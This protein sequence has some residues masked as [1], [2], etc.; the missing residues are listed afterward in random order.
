MN[1]NSLSDLVWKSQMGDDSAMEQLLL[2]SYSPILYLSNKILQDEASAMQVTREVLE[3]ISGKLASLGDPDQFQKWMCRITAA[4]CM[5]AMPLFHQYDEASSVPAVWQETLADGDSLTEEQSGQVI[6]QMVDTLP[7]N[8]RLCILLLG[9]GGLSIPAIAQLTGFTDSTVT[10]HI[11]QGQQTIQQHLWELQSR[12][13]QLS[14][15]TSLTGI[16]RVAMFSGGNQEDALPVVYGILG[17]EIPV[18]PDPGKW[19]IRI[20]VVILALLLAGILLTGGILVLKMV[21]SSAAAEPTAPA[22]TLAPTQAA[23]QPADTTAAAETT[24]ATEATEVPTTEA[25]TMESTVPET[26][27]NT[28]PPAATTATTPP[29]AST[30]TEPQT[31]GD[32]QATGEDGHTHQYDMVRSVWDCENGGSKTYQCSVCSYSYNEAVSAI[33]S[34]TFSTII[35]KSDPSCTKPGTI[36]KLCSTCQRGYVADDPD[37]PAKGHDYVTHLVVAPTADSQGY[38]SYRCTRCSDS[39]DADYVDPLPAADNGGSA[40]PDA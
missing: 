4:R 38:T 18:P 13:I 32:A 11:Q 24:E 3:T 2:Q 23:T 20:L 14:G 5:Q 26:T 22:A 37:R 9:C 17:K 8:Q 10:K 36:T 30:A 31:S 35:P 1:A 39:Y 28:A 25:A 29:A 27:E 7:K 40:E 19:I 34:H 6:Q 12:D 21:Q 16:L 15:L 33:G